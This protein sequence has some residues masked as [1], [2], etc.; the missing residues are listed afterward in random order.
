LKWSLFLHSGHST[1]ISRSDVD[2]PARVCDELDPR[3]GVGSG[4]RA[5]GQFLHAMASG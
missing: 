4:F 5:A 2:Q 1:A 3:T